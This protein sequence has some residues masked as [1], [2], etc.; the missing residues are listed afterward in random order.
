[1]THFREINVVAAALINAQGCTL[2]ARRPLHKWMGGFWELPGGK[3]EQGESKEQALT[4][5]LSE[6]LNINVEETDLVFL[7]GIDHAYPEC[8]LKMAVYVLHKW[9]NEIQNN[10]R[11]ALAWVAVDKINSYRL[12]A[13]DVEIITALES[14][15]KTSTKC[16]A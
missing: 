3:I 9:K 13:A 14:Y 5:E 11:Q 15:L 1:M 7:K 16:R 8:R 2:L 10:E 4:R 6:E 12:P